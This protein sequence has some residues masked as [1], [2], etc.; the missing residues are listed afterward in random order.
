MSTI[1]E[2]YPKAFNNNSVVVERFSSAEEVVRVNS[3]RKLTRKSYKRHSHIEDGNYSKYFHGVKSWDEAKDLMTY[4]YSPFV[5]ELQS[6]IYYTA[7]GD[8]VKTA[9]RNDVVGFAPI[10]PLMLAGVPNCM[11][12]MYKKPVKNKVINIYFDKVAVCDKTSKQIEEAC[13]KLMSAIIEAEN[14]GYRV[15]LYITEAHTDWDK[16]VDMM[17]LKV[18]DS[19]TPLDLQRLSFPLAH[20]AFFRVFGFEWF[21]RCP[22][23]RYRDGLGHN[24]SREYS[25]E[26]IVSAYEEMFKE[27]CIVFEM[28]DIITESEKSIVDSILYANNKYI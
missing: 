24:L 19:N 12:N 28:E 7:K 25:H 8:G 1:T 21:I 2:Y 17:I 3:Q 10:V 9:F 27:K 18:K 11:I 22:K 15:N 4:G 5:K 6:K 26:Q 23:A 20:P 14:Q 13:A 16:T